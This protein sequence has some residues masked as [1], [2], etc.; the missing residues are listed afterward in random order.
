M[1]EREIFNH[2]FSISNQSDDTGGVVA[3]CVFRNGEMLAE[4]VS[5]SGGVHAEYALLQKVKD[6]GLVIEPEDVVY[7]T[8]EPCGK[9]TPG[10]RGEKMGDCTTN[11]IHAGV[12]KVIYAAMDPDASSATRHRFVEVN[13]ILVQTSDVSVIKKAV[14]IFN[15]TCIKSENHLPLP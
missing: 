11:L 12:K 8:I 15:S 9:R 10:G 3:S 13:G 7:T 1:T 4:A 6:K 14:E 2:L 5:S